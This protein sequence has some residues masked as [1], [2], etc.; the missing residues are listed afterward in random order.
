M[1]R[2]TLGAP[3]G[4]TILGRQQGF[5]WSAFRLICPP[6]GAGGF[7]RYLPSTVV[8]ASGEHGAPV[9]CWANAPFAAVPASDNAVSATR[10]T[11]A[12]QKLSILPLLLYSP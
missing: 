5:D 2:S 8:V 11:R 6:N 1:I 4:G 10:S 7:G 12:V 9:V 3:F